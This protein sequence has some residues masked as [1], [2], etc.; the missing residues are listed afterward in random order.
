MPKVYSKRDVVPPGALYVGRGS[1]FGNPYI[2]GVDG[3]RA[4][5]IRKFR[6]YLFSDPVLMKAV[7][8][9]LK[10]KDLVCWCAPDPCHADVLL[11]LANGVE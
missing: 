9:Y 6:H 7:V 1:R 5:V 4:E 10:G 3:D 8:V 2:I 11:E